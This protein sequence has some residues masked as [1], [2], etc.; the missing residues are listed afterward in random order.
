MSDRIDGTAVSLAELAISLLSAA[1]HGCD[2]DGSV[3]VGG[4][5]ER[6]GDITGALFATGPPTSALFAEEEEAVVLLNGGM[7][8]MG[9]DPSPDPLLLR[10]WLALMLPLRDSMDRRRVRGVAPEVT[11]CTWE[12]IS[13]CKCETR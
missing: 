9:T 5:D 8:R 11:A 2:A 13:S 3:V 6:I 4:R 10:E 7:V 12:T 1:D